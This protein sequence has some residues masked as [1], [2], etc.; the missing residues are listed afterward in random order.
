MAKPLVSQDLAKLFRSGVFVPCSNFHSGPC[1]LQ[2]LA[3]MSKM[4]KLFTLFYGPA[5][6]LPVLI[7]KLKQLLKSP[8]PILEHLITNVVRSVFFGCSIVGIIQYLICTLPK[9]FNGYNR[10][11]WPIIG[12]LSSCTIFIEAQSR[13]GEL[14]LY[15]LPRMLETVWRIMKKKG[16]PIRIKYFEVLIFAVA[17]AI[18]TYFLH[19]DEKHIKP[20]YRSSLRM[21]LGNN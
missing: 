21:I 12:A 9:I 13:R 17:M 16:F 6:V 10:A 3:R 20:T 2:A 18:L 7:F 14:T 5:H 19:N 11:V 8:V 4:I 1:E 15:L